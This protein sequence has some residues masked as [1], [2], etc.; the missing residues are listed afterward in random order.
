[1]SIVLR[2][3]NRILAST[4]R[5]SY[6]TL[7]NASGAGTIAVV[8]TE[9]FSADDFIIIG[10][11]GKEDAEIFRIGAVNSTNKTLTLLTSAGAG[12]TTRFAHAESTKVSFIPYDTVRF[13]WTAALGTIADETPT[14]ATTTPLTGYTAL[15]AANTYTSY[16]D[17]SHT[18]GFG[19][20]IYKNSVTTVVSTNS[21]SIPYAGFSQNTVQ[22]VFADFDS[23][24]NVSEQKLVTMSDK[25]SWINEA[26]MLVKN[27]LNLSNAE[28]FVSPEQSLSIISG[29]A[30]YQLPADFSD[31]VY[32]NDGTTSKISIQYMTVSKAK[33]YIGSDTIH[34]LRGRYVGFVPTPGANTT[35]KYAY[36]SNATRVVSLSTY[37]DL[38]DG[39][40]FALKDFMLFRAHGKFKNSQAA[41]LAYTTFSNSIN[42]YIQSVVTRS[43][44]YPMWDI[45]KS[46]NV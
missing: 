30:E 12:T 37:I 41:N 34:Y 23:L 42:L 27:K 40:F 20:F 45:L 29:T 33:E 17:S 15:E 3:D 28:Y 38:P 46:S 9:G 11:F 18:S 31:M 16:T 2:A 32:L 5:Y 6:L 19:W 25:F 13:Y 1:M 8:N 21:N 7:N 44:D 10:D 36:R 22:Q 39:M 4:T 35:Y 14:F 26:I 24:L 43:D